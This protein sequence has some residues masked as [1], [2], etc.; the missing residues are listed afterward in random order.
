MKTTNQK[1]YLITASECLAAFFIATFCIAMFFSH[2]TQGWLIPGIVLIILY[3]F[4]LFSCIRLMCKH[5]SIA[6]LML[7]TP[8]VPLI[9]LLFVLILL[10]IL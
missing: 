9:A 4:V 10:P 6:A 1:L 2:L 8:I 5:F 7:L 3:L